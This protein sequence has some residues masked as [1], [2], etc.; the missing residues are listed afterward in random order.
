MR[1]LRT[2][3]QG[4]GSAYEIL[5]IEHE[6]ERRGFEPY[7]QF[8]HSF[9]N[10]AGRVAG[11][12]RLN[13]LLNPFPGDPMLVVGGYVP[14]ATCFPMSLGRASF[15]ISMIVG[16]RLSRNGNRSSSEIAPSLPF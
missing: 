4:V 9:G 5:G 11:R 8:S 16:N 7:D 13:V 6:L 1:F 15:P 3:P 2:K 10:L 14:D 12:L